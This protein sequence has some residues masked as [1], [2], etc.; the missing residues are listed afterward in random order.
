MVQQLWQ[1]ITNGG[2]GFTI[3]YQKTLWQ[4][5]FLEAFGG[6]GIQFADRKV[7]GQAPEYAYYDYDTITDP[8]YKGIL[9]KIGMNIG[10]GL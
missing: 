2:L 10:I 6:G 7:T 1:D 4:V 3:G 9:P 8:A 5:L